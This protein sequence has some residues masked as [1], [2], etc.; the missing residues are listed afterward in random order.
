MNTNEI[1]YVGSVLYKNVVGQDSQW[2]WAMVAGLAATIGLY[3][4][5]RQFRLQVLATMRTSLAE[6]TQRWKLIEML[7]AR[8]KVCKHYLEGGEKCPNSSETV[9]S[10]FEEMG[11][12]TEREVLDSAIVW[13]L[14]GEYIESYWGILAPQIKEL[15]IKEKDVTAYRFFETLYERTVSYNRREGIPSKNTPDQLK[16]FATEECKSS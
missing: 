7:T 1:T 8:K 4:I 5:Y 12:Y 16:T 6:Y 11:L 13:E 15:R 10:F 3:L 9:A 2:F 14:Y